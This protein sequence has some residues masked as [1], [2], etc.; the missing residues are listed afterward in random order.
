MSVLDRKSATEELVAKLRVKEAECGVRNPYSHLKLKLTE[1]DVLN[2]DIVIWPL[3][4]L[5]IC[6]TSVSSCAVIVA[7]EKQAKRLS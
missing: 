2:S 1:K 6:P 3:R 5:H 4:F 7:P